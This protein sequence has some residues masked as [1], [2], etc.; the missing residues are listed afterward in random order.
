MI[1]KVDAG[2]VIS[3]RHMWLPGVFED[4]RAARLAFK[5]SDDALAD[6]SKAGE[7]ISYDQ[8]LARYRAERA[9]A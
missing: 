2:Y 9:G 4:E 7:V 6:L 1:Y 3:S 5:L 8:V